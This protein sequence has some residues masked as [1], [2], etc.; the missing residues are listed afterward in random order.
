LGPFLSR[1]ISSSRHSGLTSF[2]TSMASCSSS[3]A[4]S[5]WSQSAPPSC[6]LTLYS[7]RR[8][9]SGTGP[10]FSPPDPLPLTSSYILSISSSIK[11]RCR[12]CYKS[13]TTSDTCKDDSCL[14][15]DTPSFNE[16]IVGLYSASRYFSCVEPSE[17]GEQH[18]SSTKYIGM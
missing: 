4:Y 5:S 17:F 16:V 8:I 6:P 18:S 14:S 1:C 15:Y 11:L 2:T 10:R 7:T 13:C 9:T 12:G 3:T